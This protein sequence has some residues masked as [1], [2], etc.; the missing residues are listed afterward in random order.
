MEIIGTRTPVSY[1]HLVKPTEETNLNSM[2]KFMMEQFGQMNKKLESDKE[3][4]RQ[5]KEDRRQDKENLNRILEK[6][7][8]NSEELKKQ[9]KESIES[10]SYTHLFHSLS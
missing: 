1:T 7:D 4:R 6:L 9:M 5:D 8:Q 3:E 10:V 2:M